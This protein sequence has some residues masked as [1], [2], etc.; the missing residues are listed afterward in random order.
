MEAKVLALPTTAETEAGKATQSPTK[1]ARWDD[2]F[3]FAIP[4]TMEANDQTLDDDIRDYLRDEERDYR[5]LWNQ[6]KRAESKLRQVAQRVFAIPATS[7]SVE[8]VFS[9][10]GLLMAPLRSRT[11]EVNLERLTSLRSS[12]SLYDR[13]KRPNKE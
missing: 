1:K 12:L 5:K 10:S 3:T 9:K 7:A 13:P 2:G 8:R 11:G 4:K 6:S